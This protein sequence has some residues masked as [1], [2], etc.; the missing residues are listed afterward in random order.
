MARK[1]VKHRHSIDAA[2]EHGLSQGLIESTNTKIRLLSRIAFGF[3]SPEA[4][5]ALAMLALGGHRPALPGRYHPRISQESL[6]DCVEAAARAG[7]RTDAA[8]HAQE[9]MR[10]RLAEISPRTA[11]LALAMTAMTGSDSEAGDLYQSALDHP[12]LVDSPFQYARVALAHGV[13]LRSKAHRGDARAALEAAADTFDRLGA[14]PWSQQ[15]RFELRALGAPTARSTVLTTRERRVA[16][17]AA[18]GESSRQIAAKLSISTRTV[19]A[20]LYRVFSKLGISRRAEL[21]TAL[22]ATRHCEPLPRL[23]SETG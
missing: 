21:G 3:R 1:I 5:I 14:R 11:A 20:H 10:L 6:F 15:A 4:L 17:L 16:E 7:Q 12:G 9:A 22:Q 23:S 18:T 13:W 2:L 19:D 8:R